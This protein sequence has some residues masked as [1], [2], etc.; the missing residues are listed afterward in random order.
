VDDSALY[1]IDD[2]I[3][4]ISAISTSTPKLDKYIRK[5]EALGADINA[6][7]CYGSSP[8]HVAVKLGNK[9]AAKTI[10]ASP[11]IQTFV[12]DENDLT[13]LDWPVAYGHREIA[14]SIRHRQT[15]SSGLMVGR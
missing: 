6:R 4:E 9:I 12:Q 13:P 7:D 10:L 8:L 2:N 11:K 3:N 15:L 1:N 5:L 14:S